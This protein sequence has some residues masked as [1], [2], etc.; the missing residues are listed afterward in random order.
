MGMAVKGIRVAVAGLL[1]LALAGCASVYRNHGYNPTDSDLERIVVG[2]DTRDTVAEVIGRPTAAGLL[3]DDAWFYVSSRWKH[4]AY[5]APE[6]IER[7]VLAVR[8]N[9]SGVVQNIERFGLENGKV[10]VLSSRVTDSNIKGIGF[11]RQLLGNIGN[12][13][14]ADFL[15]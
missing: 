8:F 12:I 5:R 6:E 15:K 2:V 4:F 1:M 14:A 3:N 13:Q 9:K 10:V 7:Q 11:I